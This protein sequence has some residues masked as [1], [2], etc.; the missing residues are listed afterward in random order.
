MQYTLRNRIERG[1]LIRP[2]VLD[3]RNVKATVLENCKML[4]LGFPLQGFALV[5]FPQLL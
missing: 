2:H 1:A 3:L 5:P 4:F